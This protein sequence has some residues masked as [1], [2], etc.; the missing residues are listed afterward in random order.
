MTEVRYTSIENPSHW[1]PYANSTYHRD[2]C[3]VPLCKRGHS[4]Y[5]RSHLRNLVHVQ[6]RISAWYDL[7]RGT[8]SYPYRARSYVLLAC[9]THAYAP[10][11]RRYLQFALVSQ[12]HCGFSKSNP[13]V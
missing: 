10:V 3:A 13:K 9:G 5:E 12:P 1:K 8:R 6:L 2:D 11:Q 7:S 4:L